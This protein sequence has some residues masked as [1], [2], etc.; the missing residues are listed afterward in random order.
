MISEK[1]N[2]AGSTRTAVVELFFSKGTIEDHISMKIRVFDSK[3][4]WASLQPK[5]PHP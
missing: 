5:M 3:T 1:L 4:K 2:G